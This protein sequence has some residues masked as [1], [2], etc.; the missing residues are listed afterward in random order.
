M[1]HA[2]RRG[3]AR[4]H[5]ELVTNQP[6][7]FLHVGAA[8]GIGPRSFWSTL[9]TTGSRGSRTSRERHPTPR[10]KPITTPNDRTTRVSYARASR[11]PTSSTASRCAG[12]SLA[13]TVNVGKHLPRDAPPTA[14]NPNLG[15]LARQRLRRLEGRWGSVQPRP[16]GVVWRRSARAVAEQ[17]ARRRDACYTHTLSASWKAVASPW[18]HVRG[19]AISVPRVSRRGPGCEQVPHSIRGGFALGRT[20]NDLN[21]PRWLGDR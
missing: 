1:G 6:R 2:A 12:L 21:C 14:P 5:R 11:V 19:H 17:A 8:D 10:G 9:P 13:P 7:S 4:R 18:F 16:D 15:A 3:E 20:Q